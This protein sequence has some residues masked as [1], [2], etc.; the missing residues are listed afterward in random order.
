M[1]HLVNHVSI[2]KEPL[3]SII[4]SNPSYPDIRYWKDMEDEYKER[5][6]DML[7]EYRHW[8]DTIAKHRD[9]R[10]LIYCSYQGQVKYKALCETIEVWS[11]IRQQRRTMQDRFIC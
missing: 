2:C 7:S 11:N 6:Q 3:I 8:K 1:T 10:G 4:A 5:I 9:F